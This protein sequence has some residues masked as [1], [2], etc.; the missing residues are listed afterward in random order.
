MDAD[1]FVASADVE[2]LVRGKTWEQMVPGTSFRTGTRTVTEAD[3]IQF[4]T[5]AGFTEP[6]FFDAA[7]GAE[8]SRPGRLVPAAMTYCI[9]EGLVIQTNAFNGTGL[10]FLSME[11]SARRPVYTGDTLHAVV[12]TTAARETSKPGRGLVTTRVSV[13]NHQDEEVLVY[14]PAR[15][16]RG[17][18][19]GAPA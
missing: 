13:R 5:W 14:T 1:A 2:P 9:A 15:L 7:Q 6:L 19:A 12:T 10:A 11:L 16:L 8:A 3:L 18:D 17:A 4:I